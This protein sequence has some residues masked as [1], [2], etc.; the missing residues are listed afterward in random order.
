M[1]ELSTLFPYL[2]GVALSLAFAYIPGTRE[3]GTREIGTREIGTTEI[4]TREIGTT[5]I[6]TIEIGTREIGTR[7]IGTGK[8]SPLQ[9]GIVQIGVT[10]VCLHQ[11]GAKPLLRARVRAT[12]SEKGGVRTDRGSYRQIGAGEIRVSEIGTA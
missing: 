4:G 3:I 1:N 12:K 5:E 11:T 6:G 8:V 10:Q 2:A 7:E 9:V